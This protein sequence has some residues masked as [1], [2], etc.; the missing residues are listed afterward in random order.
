[1]SLTETQDLSLLVESRVTASANGV[2]RV[3]DRYSQ[4][5]VAPG[6]IPGELKA[7]KHY[8]SDAVD[9]TTPPTL[10]GNTLAFA[11]KA[12]PGG[13]TLEWQDG[14]CSQFAFYEHDERG[15]HYIASLNP[16]LPDGRYWTGEIT[17]EVTDYRSYADGAFEATANMRD[18]ALSGYLNPVLVVRE[19]APVNRAT[20]K[21]GDSEVLSAADIAR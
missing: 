12:E 5:A 17:G 1:M 8:H 2:C 18:G 6:A 7:P 15:Y 13:I 3:V 11:G 20:N 19:P 4:I 14:Y 21:C 16:L 9:W 10:N